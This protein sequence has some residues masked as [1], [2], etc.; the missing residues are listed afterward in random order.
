MIIIPIHA[1]VFTDVLLS[2][3]GKPFCF[4]VYSRRIHL[5]NALPATGQTLVKMKSL[6]ACARHAALPQAISRL[7]DD[8]RLP[9]L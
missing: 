3:A 6:I 1:T 2:V 7:P 5:D 8:N 9:L 4:Y